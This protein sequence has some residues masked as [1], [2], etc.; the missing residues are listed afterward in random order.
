MTNKQF[1]YWLQGYLEICQIPD[2]T[3]EKVLIIESSLAKI[4]EPLGQFTQWLLKV[5]KLFTSENYKQE[6]LNYFMP[7][8]EFR[9]NSIFHHVIDNSYDSRLDKEAMQ[10]IHDGL[11]P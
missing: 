9:L 11:I 4:Y 10:R 1:C 7:V 5:T 6:L 3:K 2:L 8:I